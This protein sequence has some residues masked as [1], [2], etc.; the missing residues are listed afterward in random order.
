MLYSCIDK[1]P[2]WNKKS[3][4]SLCLIFGAKTPNHWERYT[5][6]DKGGAIDF[7]KWKDSFKIGI[8]EIDQQH[9]VFLG[10][11]NEYYL[12]IKGDKRAGMAPE[13]IKKLTAYAD[14]LPF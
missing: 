6:Y 12:Q 10:H 11:L 2:I 4:D 9:R 1:N 13:M 14:A 8:E 5:V 7:F 3:L